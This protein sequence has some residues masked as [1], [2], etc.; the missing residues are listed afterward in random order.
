M[1]CGIWAEIPLFKAV[2]LMSYLI[3]GDAGMFGDGFGHGK[4]CRDLK[5][6][7]RILFWMDH[8]IM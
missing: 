8:L 3:K 1:V 4:S 7:W 6:V 5:G 2:T